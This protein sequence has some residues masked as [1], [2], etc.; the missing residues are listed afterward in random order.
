MS[1]KNYRNR[2]KATDDHEPSR[3]LGLISGNE[4]ETDFV[5]NRT[6]GFTQFSVAKTL[7]SSLMYSTFILG[8]ASV[9]KTNPLIA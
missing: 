4:L 3:R 1:S 9:S 2:N 8:P 5:Q 7:P 6:Y